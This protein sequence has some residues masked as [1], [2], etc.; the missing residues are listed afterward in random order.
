MDYVERGVLFVMLSF[1]IANWLS[2][3]A[4][5]PGEDTIYAGAVVAALTAIGIGLFKMGKALWKGF[6]LAVSEAVD[7]SEHATYTKHH[8]G[9]NGE[10]LPL[11]K[12]VINLE[13][14]QE[15]LRTAQ[16]EIVQELK[17]QSGIIQAQAE[18]I[19]Q[20]GD[21]Q[22]KTLRTH[23]AIV[24]E[25]AKEAAIKVAEQLVRHFEESRLVSR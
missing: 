5:N 9:P 14:N 10:T 20:H 12:R 13:E 15:S 2:H 24:E 19:K 22:W 4:E 1:I 21:S 11:W 8:L 18:Q 3:F 6:K 16:T 23:E 25:A 7:T 17:T